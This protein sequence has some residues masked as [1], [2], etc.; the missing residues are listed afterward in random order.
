VPELPP[1]RR[2]AHA[3]RMLARAEKRHRQ[4]LKLVE[5]WKL[6]IAELDRAGV[7]ARQ[8]SL[9]A[10]EHPEALSDTVPPPDTL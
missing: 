9:W 7:A 10:D 2:R 8:A 4:A 6:R 1:D 3:E 5:R